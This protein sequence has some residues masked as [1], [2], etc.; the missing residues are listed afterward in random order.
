VCSLANPSLSLFQ[1]GA[2]DFRATG[3]IPFEIAQQWATVDLDKLDPQ[4]IRPG[5]LVKLAILHALDLEN[6]PPTGN[7]D[8]TLALG[9]DP[10]HRPFLELYYSLP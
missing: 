6:T 7:D 9:D 10:I 2:V 4:C 3:R 5:S 1:F 8:I